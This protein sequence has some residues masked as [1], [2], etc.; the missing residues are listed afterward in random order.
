V[1]VKTP[2]SEE[3]KQPEEEVPEVVGE[4]SDMFADP[5]DKPTGKI[6]SMAV[7]QE[8]M[9]F[10]IY[11]RLGDIGNVLVEILRRLPDD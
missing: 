5:F 11:K 1:E 4:E 9:L 3:E 2:L 8:Q 10:M 6:E 7:S